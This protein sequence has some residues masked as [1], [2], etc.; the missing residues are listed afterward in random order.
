MSTPT[1]V[2]VFVLVRD[3]SHDTE[4]VGIYAN[5]PALE[6]AVLEMLRK[7]QDLG[8]LRISPTALQGAPAGPSASPSPRTRS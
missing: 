6:A 4:I 2:Q 1:E 5:Q 8:G 7:G 3:H